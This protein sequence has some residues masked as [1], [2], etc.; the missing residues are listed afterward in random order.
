MLIILFNE[1]FNHFNAAAD[2]GGDIF[3]YTSGIN[4]VLSWAT[5]LRQIDIDSFKVCVCVC[6]R[7]AFLQKRFVH[8]NSGFKEKHIVYYGLWVT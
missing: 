3:N 6:V 1:E 5:M 4:K 8:F 7:M 2:K